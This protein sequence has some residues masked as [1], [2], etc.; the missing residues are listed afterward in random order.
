MDLLP[1][2]EAELYFHIP[3]GG[4]EPFRNQFETA[5]GVHE[6]NIEAEATHVP[7]FDARTLADAPRLDSDGHEPVAHETDVD[8]FDEEAIRSVCHARRPD[9]FARRTGLRARSSSTTRWAEAG[10]APPVSRSGACI[11]TMP[12]HRGC[13]GSAT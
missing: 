9:W 8:F 7:I 11:T 6:T 10:R 4:E 3:T 2:T 5:F 12:R 1:R 13:C